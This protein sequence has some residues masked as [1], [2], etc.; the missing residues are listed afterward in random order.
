MT[1]CT[2][3]G[4]CMLS[5]TIQQKE[6]PVL[7][8]CLPRNLSSQHW[9]LQWLAWRQ[10]RFR[11]Q[12]QAAWGRSKRFSPK[13]RSEQAARMRSL[14]N[15]LSVAYC[16]PLCRRHHQPCRTAVTNRP[17]R[18]RSATLGSEMAQVL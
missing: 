3:L 8:L 13:G 14:I 17:D 5:W 6:G 9:L 2:R 1:C 7:L 15:S 12:A 16:H 18:G 4:P 11:I 10:H